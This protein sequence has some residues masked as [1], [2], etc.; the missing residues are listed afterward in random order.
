MA[1]DLNPFLYMEAGELR[2]TQVHR[3]AEEAAVDAR[4]TRS[5]L[6]MRGWKIVADS[7]VP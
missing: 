1:D 4:A 5:R 6:Q 7:A 2:R 3:D